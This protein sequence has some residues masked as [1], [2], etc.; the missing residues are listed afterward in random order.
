MD[1]IYETPLAIVTFGTI[2]ARET[3]ECYGQ[4]IEGKTFYHLLD[5]SIPSSSLKLR[6]FSPTMT[7]SLSTADFNDSQLIHFWDEIESEYIVC[8]ENIYVQRK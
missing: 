8:I 5:K 7:S 6:L 2:G 1:K 4:C 3:V